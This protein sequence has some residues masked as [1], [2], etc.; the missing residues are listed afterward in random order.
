M[1]SDTAVVRIDGNVLLSLGHLYTHLIECDPQ[2]WRGCCKAD[3]D[4]MHIQRR[5]TTQPRDYITRF[6]K[7][8]PAVKVDF[9]ISPAV[10]ESLY[11]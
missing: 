6:T 1:V 5:P 9:F 4:V 3:A 7:N 8:F 2:R 10:R 11:P